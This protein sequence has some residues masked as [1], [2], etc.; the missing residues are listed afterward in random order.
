MLLLIIEIALRLIYTDVMY[1]RVQVSLVV[2]IWCKA[3]I[4]MAQ[5]DRSSLRCQ[6][7]EHKHH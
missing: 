4:S 7:D 3:E 6:G 2:I 5:K 1:R